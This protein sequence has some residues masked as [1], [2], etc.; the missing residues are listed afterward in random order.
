MAYDTNTKLLLH[1]D[2]SDGST[3]FTDSETTPKTV[4]AN[5]SAQ[6]DTAQSKFGG[7]SGLIGPQANYLSLADSAGFEFTGNFFVSYWYKANARTNYVRP[8]STTE[9][10]S[11]TFRGWWLG[12]GYT[13]ATNQP[14]EFYAFNSSGGTD[15]GI[16]GTTDVND[17]NWHYLE[18]SRS[19]SSVYLFL[20]G[21]QQGSTATFAGTIIR[22]SGTTGLMIGRTW[23]DLNQVGDYM[24]GW[25]DEL[26][27]VNGTAGHTGNYTPPIAAWDNPVA[28]GGGNPSY[29][30]FL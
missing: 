15:V 9:Y 16:S 7:S 24:N 12:W 21:V 17:G 3:T 19:G 4:T 27:I 25:L 20:D 1:M 13:N 14:A 18:V 8:V 6:I 5:G 26:I 29:S 23:T 2:G 10:N 30:F 22:A 28:V 11:A